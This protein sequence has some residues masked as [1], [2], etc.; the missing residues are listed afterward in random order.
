VLKRFSTSSVMSAA[1]SAN[2]RP[3]WN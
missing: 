1:S 2:T 3:D